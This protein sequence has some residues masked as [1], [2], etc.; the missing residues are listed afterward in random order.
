M[1]DSLPA[2][3]CHA[4][5]KDR[6]GIGDVDGFDGAVFK[7]VVFHHFHELGIIRVASYGLRLAGCN[8]VFDFTL[9]EAFVTLANGLNHGHGVH[10]LHVDVGESV[11]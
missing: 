1:V 4:Q 3:S 7:G 6:A 5:A 9:S 8:G 2:H 11:A 10:G